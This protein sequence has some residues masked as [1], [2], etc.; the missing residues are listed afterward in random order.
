MKSVN[1]QS[2]QMLV[3]HV[4][5]RREDKRRHLYLKEIGLSRLRNGVVGTREEAQWVRGLPEQAGRCDFGSP[6]PT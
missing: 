6:K 5:C 1:S 2:Q 4:Y 3:E